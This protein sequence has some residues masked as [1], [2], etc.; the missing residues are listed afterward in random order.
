MMYYI[1]SATGERY[2]FD[3]RAWQGR[4]GAPL[5]LARLPPFDRALIAPHVWSLWRYRALLPLPPLA[6]PVS[7]GEGMTPLVSTTLDGRSV[8]FKLEFLGPTGSYKDRGVTTL[9]SGLRANGVAEVIED[10]AGNAGTAVA[11]YA[12][13]AGLRARIFV[14]DYASPAKKAQIRVYG[15]E[16]VEV[17]GGRAATTDA[18][19]QAAQTSMYAS[20]A[21][22]PLFISGLR[23][24]AWEVWEQLGGRAPDAC[25]V[26]IGQGGLYLGLLQGFKDL[27]AA[28]EI[29]R[30]PRLFGVQP[31][32]IA[33]V[34]R[35]WQAG[36]ADVPPVPEGETIAEG[37]RIRQPV[38][39]AQL[40]AGA[41]ESGGGFVAVDDPAIERARGDL[42]HAG[43]F[44]E[45]TSAAALAGLR[46]LD[47]VIPRDALVVVPLTG[48]GLKAPPQA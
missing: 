3:T 12:A 39:G 13:A 38:R 32:A 45:P 14:P 33:P 30:L 6:Q 18:A 43:L 4:S 16:L 40:L 25:V 29:D 5:E 24:A 41:T 27:L 2:P 34:A 1:D 19:V 20:H 35:A 42:A 8:H 21:W 31:T 23:T 7:L 47:R 10:S 46:A 37:I 9:I 17:G 22:H 44:V 28:G 11:A 26:P 36:R 48:S 15:A